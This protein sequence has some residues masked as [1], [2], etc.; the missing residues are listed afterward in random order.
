MSTRNTWLKCKYTLNKTGDMLPSEWALV[1][2]PCAIRAPTRPTC[3]PATAICSA[4]RFRTSSFA[5]KSFSESNSRTSCSLPS[6]SARANTVSHFRAGFTARAFAPPSW[7]SSAARRASR[8]RSSGKSPSLL[9]WL[10]SA[11]CESASRM[12][13]AV[14]SE[15]GCAQWKRSASLALIALRSPIKCTGVEVVVIG[16]GDLVSRPSA[17][18]SIS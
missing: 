11:P 3:P 8:T 10:A 7:M 12:R 13:C 6:C 1:S 5:L 15:K 16:G 2:A 18:R 9:R 17:S 4:R 14:R